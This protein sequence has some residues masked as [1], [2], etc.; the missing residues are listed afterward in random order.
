VA[1]GFE[2]DILKDIFRWQL[3]RRQAL[4]AATSM[5]VTVVVVLIGGVTYF[6]REWHRLPTSVGSFLLL[7][8]VIGCAVAVAC[9]IWFLCATMWEYW[10][11]D[12]PAPELVSKY[13]RGLRE[14]YKAAGAS[15]VEQAAEERFRKQLVEDYRAAGQINFDTNALRAWYLFMAR[16]CII[17]ATA[18]LAVS[19]VGLAIAS[20]ASGPTTTQPSAKRTCMADQNP[21]TPAPV[22]QASPPSSAP[23]ARPSSPAPEPSS[24]VTPALPDAP[25]LTLCRASQRPTATKGGSGTE[26]RG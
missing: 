4:D 23:Q 13:I 19:G 5:P 3:Q 9:A 1:G 10:I 12:L 22:Q 21:S 20:V 26:K 11:A 8:G 6:A 18:A 24:T 7:V 25:P 14:A 2:E 15:D 17:I 16:R